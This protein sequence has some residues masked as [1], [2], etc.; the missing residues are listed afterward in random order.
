MSL[1]EKEFSGGNITPEIQ[2]QKMMKFFVERDFELGILR[3]N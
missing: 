1:V 3:W 2:I